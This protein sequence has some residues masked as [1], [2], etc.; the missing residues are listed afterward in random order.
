M[1]KT[2]YMSDFFE[3]F[4]KHG[5]A[6]QFKHTLPQ[7]FDY[8]EEY[9]A[10]TGEELELDV[11]AICCDFTEWSSE[12]LAEE[13]DTS[14]EIVEKILAEHFDNM[15]TRANDGRLYTI[16]SEAYFIN[17]RMYVEEEA[18]ESDEE[19]REQIAEALEDLA[20][21]ISAIARDV[22]DDTEPIPEMLERLE[23]Y[24]DDFIHDYNQDV[25]EFK[26]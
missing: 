15:A 25:E 6:N 23:S 21:N 20:K 17:L 8:L 2:V 3:A 26:D 14:V 16:L 12:D 9:E 24:I 13:F 10:D 5:R 7:L 1:K 18:E 11:I 22:E 4:D 19:K